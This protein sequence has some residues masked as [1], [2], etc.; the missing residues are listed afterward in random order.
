MAL[1]VFF[2][3]S[4]TP[5][6]VTAGVITVLFTRFSL[7]VTHITLLLASIDEFSFYLI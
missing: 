1:V 7:G 5:C 6:I 4:V 3:G 2:I